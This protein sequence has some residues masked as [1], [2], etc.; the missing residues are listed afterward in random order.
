MSKTREAS[1]QRCR[2]PDARLIAPGLHPWKP[3]FAS[4]S[5][6]ARTGRMFDTTMIP[7]YPGSVHGHLGKVTY[8]SGVMAAGGPRLGG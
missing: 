4:L 1:D 7:A 3:S 8:Q 5:F 6:L 2:C